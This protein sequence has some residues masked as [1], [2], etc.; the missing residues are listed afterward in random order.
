MTGQFVNPALRGHVAFRVASVD[1]VKGRLKAMN[2][3]FADY[4]EWAIPNCHQVY[5]HDPEGN[6]L[7]VHQIKD[8]G[9]I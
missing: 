8:A 3:P 1:A 4:G 5:F 7:E 6:V 2:V 9:G